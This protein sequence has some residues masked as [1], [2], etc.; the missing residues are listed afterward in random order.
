MGGLRI[1]RIVIV[2]GLFSIT[3]CAWAE[4]SILPDTDS[5]MLSIKGVSVPLQLEPPCALVRTAHNNQYFYHYGDSKVF[6]VAG[7]PAPVEQLAKWSVTAAD[8]CS[9]QSQAIIVTKDKVRFTDKREGALTCPE[10]GVDEK[11]YRDF[12]N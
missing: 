1:I 5:C 12:L 2:T 7:Q 8:K 10:I 9:L 4:I 6:I 3:A 11:V